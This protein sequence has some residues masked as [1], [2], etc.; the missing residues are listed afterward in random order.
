MKRK[1]TLTY[2]FLYGLYSDRIRHPHLVRLAQW[3]I[4]T[5]SPLRVGE[6][7]CR[8]GDPQPARS[9]SLIVSWMLLLRRCQAACD[10]HAPRPMANGFRRGALPSALVT[11]GIRQSV[12][13]N[14]LQQCSRPR[15]LP[16]ATIQSSGL[17]REKQSKFALV[18]MQISWKVSVFPFRGRVK[19]SKIATFLCDLGANY[20]L[21]HTVQ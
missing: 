10:G 18:P 11:H 14:Q 17:P 2:P 8:K 6:D 7:K 9:S 16:F 5:Y 3:H 12:A 19:D 21:S 13:Y 4:I 1:L 15:T 20:R